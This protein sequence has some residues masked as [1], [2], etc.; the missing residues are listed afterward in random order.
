[1]DRSACTTPKHDNAAMVTPRPLS[2]RNNSFLTDLNEIE[3]RLN[4]NTARSSHMRLDGFDSDKLATVRERRDKRLRDL[5]S[6]STSI[7][8]GPGSHL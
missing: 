4:I 3:Q 6:N 7:K 1:M 2:P 5:K 8:L